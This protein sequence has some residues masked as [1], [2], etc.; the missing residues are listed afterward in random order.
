MNEADRK[1]WIQETAS[2]AQAGNHIWPEYAA[3][4][5][6]L[7]SNFGQSELAQKGFNL[8]G[9]KVHTH[10]EYGQLGEI[11]LPTKEFINGEWV[12]KNA[13]FI[14]YPRLADC[15]TDRMK[16]LQRLRFAYPHYNNALN[17][18]DGETFVREVS[19]TWSTDP[20]R[21]EKVLSIYGEFFKN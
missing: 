21:A 1:S 5:G 9:M 15:F 2:E 8:F 14:A 11:A 13:Y 19:Q 10:S 4:E 3:C 18:P 16:T 6:A 7:E 20:N 17:A 12:T